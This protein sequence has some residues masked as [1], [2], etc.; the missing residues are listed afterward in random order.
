MNYVI[1]SIFL[2]IVDIFII[3]YQYNLLI[4]KSKIVNLIPSWKGTKKI[5]HYFSVYA[6]AIFSNVIVYYV[7]IIIFS[8]FNDI[9]IIS[10]FISFQFMGIVEIGRMIVTDILIKK[11]NNK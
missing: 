10:F 11:K 5:S 4:R 2:M 8:K 1:Q 3:L 9:L 7:L 6:I